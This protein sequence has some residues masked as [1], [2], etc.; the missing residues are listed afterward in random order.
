MGILTDH[1]IYLFREGTH[2]TLYKRLGCHFFSDDDKD[3]A[4]VAVW[5]P[6]ARD[7]SVIGD[8]NGWDPT[9]D[10]L[11]PRWDHSGIWEADI[12]GIR[13]GQSYK[14]AITTS[15]GARQDRADPYAFCT[16]ITPATPRARGGSTTIGATASG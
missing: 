10:K 6:N 1:D 3:G 9:A 16:E 13:P 7:I 11:F 8:W 15:H 5:A 14:F 2:S 12:A 4:H